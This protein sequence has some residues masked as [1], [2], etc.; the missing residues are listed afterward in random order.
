MEFVFVLPNKKVDKI[1]LDLFQLKL[2]DSELIEKLYSNISYLQEKNKSLEEEIK[3]LKPKTLVD[4]MG[5]T[6]KVSNFT[7]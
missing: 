5:N 2:E 6:F 4:H 7:I 1:N 3:F